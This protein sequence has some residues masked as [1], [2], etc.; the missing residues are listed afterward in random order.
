M[1]KNISDL[2]KRIEISSNGGM[3]GGFGSIRGGF[4][5][6]DSINDK[7][8]NDFSCEGTNRTCTNSTSC[9]NTTNQGKCSNTA[10]CN[11]M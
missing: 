6:L 7:C 2:I 5:A 8:Q 3:S 4:A 1:K 10:T 11:I 9:G